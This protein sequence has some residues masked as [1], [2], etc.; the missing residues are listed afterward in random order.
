MT[1]QRMQI[2]DFNQ[3]LV[4]NKIYISIIEYVIE[5][6]EKFFNIN[7]NFINHFMD[8]VHKDEYSINHELLI[9]YGVTSYQAGS[10]DG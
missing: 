7:I 3:K 9:Q 5:L 10:Y 2:Q 8:L 1:N 6:N 4:E